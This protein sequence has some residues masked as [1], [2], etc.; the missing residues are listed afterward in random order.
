[1]FD[2]KP[3]YKRFLVYLAASFLLLTAAHYIFMTPSIGLN[4]DKTPFFL[5]F[6]VFVFIYSVRDDLNR[7]EHIKWKKTEFL[8]FL[9]VFF[10]IQAVL[11]FALNQI[12]NMSHDLFKNNAIY[13]FYISNF[14][15]VVSVLVLVPAVFNF[16]F[17]VK[18]Y[19]KHENR[20]LL[21]VLIFLACLVFFFYLHQNWTFFSNIVTST[22]AAAMP[23]AN[24]TIDIYWG[25]PIITYR[26]FT[27]DIGAP[28]S[29]VESISLFI[30]V[31]AALVINNHQKINFRKTV[32]F[33]I[34][35]TFGIFL[36]DILR[37]I[38]LVWIGG[39]ISKEI[40]LGLFH[41]DIGWIFYLVYIMICI[42][43]F[44]VWIMKKEES[45]AR[46]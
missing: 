14:V 6:F 22:T 31:F 43:I 27:A 1:M 40:A 39:N 10:L 30:F 15:N 16:D 41:N 42:K 28:C 13:L 37:V 19:K 12:Y 18:F 23:S 11:S 8:F 32:P 17:A 25:T 5:L 4:T 21:N 45:K 7:I 9:G 34:L 36:I 20:I 46:T 24:A 2:I 33:L 44:L 3:F 26:G 38:I 35:G 29:G